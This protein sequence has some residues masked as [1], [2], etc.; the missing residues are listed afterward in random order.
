MKVANARRG[1]ALIGLV[2]CTLLAVLTGCSGPGCSVPG[3]SQGGITALH[4]AGVSTASGASAVAAQAGTLAS[5]SCSAT[6]GG[7]VLRAKVVRSAGISPLLMFFDATG[8]SD[9]ARLAGANNAFQ[10]IS[11]SWSFGDTG[12]SGSGTWAYGANAGH[13]SKNTASGAVAAHLYVTNGSD[14]T[15]PV[16]VTAYDGTNTASCSLGVTAYNPSGANGFPG[17]ATTCVAAS[18]LPVAGSG[19]CPAGAGVL[20]QSNLGTAL[21]SA[22]ANN[23]RVLFKCGDSF[24]G[25]YLIASGS[26]NATIGAYGGCENTT[27][28][29]PVFSNRSGSPGLN[30]TASHQVDIRITDIDFEGA[31]VQ[32]A[33]AVDTLSSYSQVQITLYNLLCHNYQQCYYLDQ[34]TQSG[35]IA[36]QMTNMLGTRTNGVQG[37]FINYYG[38]TCYNQSSAL[39]CA[40]GSTTSDCPIDPTNGGIFCDQRYNALIGNFFDG[41]GAA[42]NTAPNGSETV[43]GAF[44]YSV[45]SN[46]TLQNANY[47]GGVLKLVSNPARST[48]FNGEYAEYLEVS[49]NFITGRSG[50]NIVGFGPVNNTSDQRFRYVIFERNLLAQPNP[51]SAT[52]ASTKVLIDAD[53]ATARNNVFYLGPNCNN[54]NYSCADYN[55]QFAQVTPGSPIPVASEFYNNTCYTRTTQSGCVGFVGGA[56]TAGP[57]NSSFAR[58]NLFYN[59]GSAGNAVTNNGAGNTVSNNTTNSAANPLLINASGSFRLISDF[60]PTQNYFG[61]TEVPAWYDALGEAWSPTWYLGA[62]KP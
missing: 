21:T 46:N 40:G 56:S 15:Y 37:V 57:G 51:T 44:R 35:V 43:R 49:D 27:S 52:A 7:L 24:T 59:N 20:Q 3:T 42:D 23:K 36:S 17:S 28:N 32:S 55:I 12:V 18:G 22:F 25:N 11:Y 39:N 45:I 5:F 6:S 54:A 8:T 47:I 29:R 62:L 31:G 19:G 41:T 50:N 34:P 2:L 53:N 16:T 58:N 33:S 38:W 60:Q 48:N 9:S 13:N 1:R 4:A 26:H 30:L 10:D 61:G 14:T